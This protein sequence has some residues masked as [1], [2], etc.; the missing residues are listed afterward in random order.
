MLAQCISIIFIF[1]FCY[2]AIDENPIM[3]IINFVSLL[4]P[5]VYYW[6]SFKM[7]STLH[8][9][10]SLFI[11]LL[12]DIIKNICEQKIICCLT[13]S[14]DTKCKPLYKNFLPEVINIQERFYCVLKIL[15][16]TRDL[17]PVSI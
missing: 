3:I 10:H 12:S 1:N 11:F 14:A 16:T 7:C 15:N 9:K 6:L 17:P 2:I 13:K 8:L 5:S 4:S